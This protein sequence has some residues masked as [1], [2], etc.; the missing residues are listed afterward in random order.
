MMEWIIHGAEWF[1]GLFQKGGEV[2]TGMVTGILPLLIALLVA[3]NALIRLIGQDRVEKLAQR[4]AGNPVSRYLVLPVIG[5]FIFCNPMTLSLGRFLPERYKPSY[6]AAA[7]YS[8]HSMNGLFPHINPGE[9]FV[10]LGIASGLTTLGLP[11]GPLAVSY[12]LVGMVTNFFRGWIT[13]FTTSMVERQQGVQL[14]RQ[15]HFS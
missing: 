4:S 12:L 11:L 10:Y 3:M 5:T 9:L 7:S 8:C 1:I 6:Y 13:D 2:F 15:V 14:E